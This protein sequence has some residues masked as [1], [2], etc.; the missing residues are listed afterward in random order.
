MI[1][2]DDRVHL[3][4][5]RRALSNGNAAVMVG[6]GFSKNAEGGEQM[7]SWQELADELRSA[8][9]LPNESRGMVAAEATQ[10][11]EQ[12]ARIF[13]TSNLEDLL[14]RH[15]PDERVFPS[16]LHEQFMRLPW[17]EIF[18]TNYDTLLERTADQIF[19]S[20]FVTVSAREDI[21]R[22]RLLGRRR[23]IKLHGSFPSQRPFIFTEEDYRTYPE[24]FAPFVNTVRQSLLENVFCL[25]GFSGS[26][27]NFLHWIGWVR[28]MLD[29]H[30]LP[31][32]LFV[33]KRPSLGEAKLLEARGVVAVTLPTPDGI[34]NSDYAARHHALF[35]M[36]G[37][38]LQ[39]EDLAWGEFSWNR[40]M[41]SS[42]PTLEERIRDLHGALPILLQHRKSYP[43]WL[44]APLPVRTRLKKSR[45]ALQLDFDN[46]PML[47]KLVEDSPLLG[48]VTLSCQAWLVEV[49]LEPTADHVGAICVD[50]LKKTGNSDL[51]SEP[52]ESKRLFSEN[53]VGPRE[54]ERCWL[55]LALHVLKWMRQGL[56]EQGFDELRHLILLDR[57]VDSEII[58][59]IQYQ[60]VL[61]RVYQGDRAGARALVAGWKVKDAHSFM[62]IRRGMLLA[63][64]GSVQEGNATC[65]SAIQS[66]RRSQKMQPGSARLLSR[67]AWA[68]LLA[69]Y[70][71]MAGSHAAR[72]D[73]PRIV[74]EED[75]QASSSANLDE[76]LNALANRGH[77]VRFEINHLIAEVSTEASMPS[78]PQTKARGFELGVV[79]S[80]YRF[81]A[82]SEFSSKVKASFAWLELVELVGMSPRVPGMQIHLDAFV[83]SGWWIQYADSSQRML[84][85]L[86]RTHEPAYLKPSDATLPRHRTGWLSRYQVARMSAELSSRI[87]NSSLQQVEAVLSASSASKRELEMICH[88]HAEVFSRLA[89]RLSDQDEV[90]L[91][92]KRVIAL[93]ARE[94]V[95]A[96]PNLWPLIGRALQR[97]FEALA[98]SNAAALVPAVLQLPLVPKP[99]DYLGHWVN[100]YETFDDIEAPDLDVVKN[101]CAGI[102]EN[103]FEQLQSASR[104]GNSVVTEQAWK[105]LMWMNS[106]ALLPAVA[107][108]RMKQ[109]LWAEAQLSGWPVVPGHRPWATLSLDAA[110][111]SSERRYLRW[112]HLQIL[113][114]FRAESAELPGLQADRPAWATARE[115]EPLVSWRAYLAQGRTAGPGDKDACL[116]AILNWWGAEGNDLTKELSGDRVRLG[117]LRS[118]LIQR[119]DIVDQLIWRIWTL[120]AAPL[121]RPSAAI[122]S[123]LP[124]F[125]EQIEALGVR[126]WR[127]R[128]ALATDRGD[129]LAMNAI[130]KDLA[131]E[132]L[133]PSDGD[134]FSQRP[135]VK[136]WI[137]ITGNP[138]PVLFRSLVATVAANRPSGL[139]QALD[140]LSLLVEEHPQWIDEADVTLVITGLAALASKLSY[141]RGITDSGI[142]DEEVPILRFMCA[143]LALALQES[144]RDQ[145]SQMIARTWLESATTDPLPE[146]RLKRFSI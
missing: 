44:V 86:L 129:R 113:R 75:G 43:D 104:A 136:D 81:G 59:Q 73:K 46:E 105:R 84:S 23:I 122:W 6:A 53:G 55:H 39:V 60:Q 4:A 22:S 106:A 50:L 133:N 18:T 69:G 130:D 96:H 40:S 94:N 134:R 2:P 58:D 67:E 12:Y 32:Y 124:V 80:S 8:L 137:A 31:I 99:S 9:G 83:R 71:K 30:T 90:T 79:T 115:H 121:T 119:G 68:C 103:L 17:C 28:D 107:V 139:W 138:A 72:F 19:E 74:E 89:V 87:A 91:F 112:L 29:R 135:V 128:L 57:V 76:R 47:K 10:L 118:G 102:F 5:L 45:A 3:N 85:I 16:A 127:T 15:I 26:D 41:Q 132:F 141:T 123:R 144:R 142:E 20:A 24:R 126:L 62:N 114:T 54:L 56:D 77:D 25:I 140:A 108:A 35:K 146:M 33:G 110:G 97:S 78:S 21:P 66:L 116:S 65:L 14:R 1:H 36:L 120:S 42:V 101:E 63:E 49:L 51:A 93:H 145:V 98:S 37:E 70:L 64:M 11:A 95:I 109:M 131:S 48:L 27:P 88:F 100:V 125:A 92:A 111:S 82:S 117:E 13:S 38:P 143:R 7:K 52:S 61:L 34:E